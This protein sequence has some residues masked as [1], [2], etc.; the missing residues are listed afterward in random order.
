M[1]KR[2]ARGLMGGLLAPDGSTPTTGPSAR[3]AAW[4][5]V[6][7]AVGISLQLACVSSNHQNFAFCS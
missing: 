7:V 3:C 1:R 4:T 6:V 2:V 5:T